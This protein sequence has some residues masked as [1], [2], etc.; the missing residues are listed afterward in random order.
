M[1]LYYIDQ[2][3][4]RYYAKKIDAIK[5]AKDAA[6]TNH[7]EVIVSQM[8][9]GTNRENIT[10]LANKEEG[11]AR[12]IGRVCTVYPRKRPK[13]KLKRVAAVVT[14]LLLL[15]LPNLAKAASCTTRRNGSVII[16]TCSGKN[17]SSHCRSY[18]SGSVVKTYCR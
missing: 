4:I 7:K 5:A 12:F 1:N 2:G 11:F 9:I 6:N 10:L 8:F 16:T 3:E 15:L 18:R 14:L 13:L 17:Y